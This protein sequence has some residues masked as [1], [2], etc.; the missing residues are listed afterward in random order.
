M[1]KMCSKSLSLVIELVLQQEVTSW[2]NVAEVNKIH[3]V[4]CTTHYWTP[5]LPEM[6]IICYRSK[7]YEVRKSTITYMCAVWFISLLYR[8]IFLIPH[9]L[10]T[11]HP[12]M[13]HFVLQ[14][15]GKEEHKKSLNFIIKRKTWNVFSI[16]KGFQTTHS[17]ESS[18]TLNKQQYLTFIKKLHKK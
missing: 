6:Y 3:A 8:T 11:S 5:V 15:A 1:T 2:F 13:Q 16:S 18:A 14:S 7:F 17:T 10:Q 9:H 12:Q 4:Q